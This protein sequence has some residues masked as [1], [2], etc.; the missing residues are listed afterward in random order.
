MTNIKAI[1]TTALTRNF[2]TLTAVDEIDL[3]ISRGEVVGFLGPNGA[4]KTTTMRMLVGSLQPTS[5]SA[6]IFGLDVVDQGVQARKHIGYVPEEQSAYCADMKVGSFCKYIA[7]LKGLS[8]EKLEE[9]VSEKLEVVQIKHLEKRKISHLSSGQ[10]QRVGLAQALIGNPDVVIAD[11]PTANLDPAGKQDMIS[12]IRSLTHEDSSRAFFV[13]THILGEAEAVADRIVILNH[14]KIVAD[15][16][17][18]DLKQNYASQTFFVNVSDKGTL[19]KILDDADWVLETNS[20]HGGL[21]IITN[22]PEKLFVELPKAIATHKLSLLM[23]R[24]G[25]SKLESLF[26]ELTKQKDSLGA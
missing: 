8:G 15:E 9:E 1:E 7:S 14:G 6:K 20:V 22:D 4:G 13:S 26:F 23:F 25:K 21:E 3:S 10:K 24:P 12:L 11:E 2:G 16:A 5:G 18:Q 19:R 17:L